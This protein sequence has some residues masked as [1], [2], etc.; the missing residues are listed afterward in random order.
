MPPRSW[1]PTLACVGHTTATSARHCA[2]AFPG[3]RWRIFGSAR[4]MRRSGGSAR[5]TGRRV[6]RSAGVRPTAQ[7]VKDAVFNS[8]AAR[9]AGARVLDLFAGTGRLGMEALTRG[10]A[11][12]VFVER[13][14]RHAAL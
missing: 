1:R 6:G 11:E 8:L 12:A 14:P 2:A 10:A 7:R 13:D 9:V 3:R 5:G 4:E